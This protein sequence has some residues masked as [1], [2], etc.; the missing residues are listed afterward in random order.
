[1][2]V[3]ASST[4]ILVL[5]GSWATHLGA[6]VAVSFV[7]GLTAPPVS[8]LMRALWPRVVRP[9]LQAGLYSLDATIVEATFIAGPAIVG[10]S[11]WLLGTHVTLAICGIPGVVGVLLLISHPVIKEVARADPV[12]NVGRRQHLLSRAFFPVLLV[13]LLAAFSFGLIE[14]AVVAETARGSSA[15]TAGLVF[16]IAG[17]GSV[18]GG[19]L[20]GPTIIAGG[21][22][23][24]GTVLLILSAIIAM[25][26]RMHTPFTITANLA[27]ANLFLTPAIGSIYAKVAT[28]YPELDK[29]TT[30]G[31]LF[32]TQIS[33]IAAGNLLAGL[34]IDRHGGGGPAYLLASGCVLVAAVQIRWA[35]ST[36]RARTA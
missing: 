11:S 25:L 10:L 2:G 28:D 16:A 18:V 12:P 33:A 1:M 24:L 31:W 15:S 9:P 21:H 13:P 8:A 22:R 14:I 4:G 19:L 26:P 35:T 36:V 3:T 30:F 34:I 20:F 29:F 7:S 23:R 17:L 6:T 27:V 32:S 5:S